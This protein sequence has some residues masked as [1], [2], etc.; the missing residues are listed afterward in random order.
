M[1]DKKNLTPVKTYSVTIE[2]STPEELDEMVLRA[3]LDV[4]ER[5]DAARRQR[6]VDFMRGKNAR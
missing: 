4:H 6:I 5:R 1:K 2:G 3:A